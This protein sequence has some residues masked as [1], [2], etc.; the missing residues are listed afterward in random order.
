M[1]KYQVGDKVK[2]KDYLDPN[3]AMV[4][5]M[6]LDHGGKVR[7]IS[8]V[9]SGVGWKGQPLFG[10]ELA[11]GP[12]GISTRYVFLDED[13]E[14][15]VSRAQ[16]ETQRIEIPVPGGRLVAE[17][18]DW[19]GTHPGIFLSFLKSGETE[20]QI[21]CFAEVAV[22]DDPDTIRVGTFYEDGS[23]VKEVFEYPMPKKEEDDV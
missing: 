15:L 17:T 14:C 22:E 3:G 23:D 9:V 13:I 21:L 11:E 4:E 7:T 8:K 18:C 5:F 12:D 6:L 2:I 20:D 1:S 10:Y 16:H 19:G